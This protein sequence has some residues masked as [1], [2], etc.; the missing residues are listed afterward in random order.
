MSDNAIDSTF[1]R[2]PRAED[3]FFYNEYLITNEKIATARN[4][5]TEMEPMYMITVDMLTPKI[6]NEDAFIAKFVNN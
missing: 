1:I 2:L 3:Y 4:M 6:T 5:L